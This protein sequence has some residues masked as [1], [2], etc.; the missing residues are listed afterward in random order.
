MPSIKVDSCLDEWLFLEDLPFDEYFD[1]SLFRTRSEN[2]LDDIVLDPEFTTEVEVQRENLSIDQCIL[3]SPQLSLT[4]VRIPELSEIDST[5]F[6]S[7]FFPS[8]SKVHPSSPFIPSL[9]HQPIITYQTPITPSSS[10]PLVSSSS[11]QSP[12]LNPAQLR[13]MAN[14]YAPLVF[15]APLGAMPQDYQNKII[16]FDGIGPY[17]T[18]QHTEKMTDH[19]ELHEID[20]EDVQM[21]LFAQTL[22]GDVRT[23]FRSLPANNINT[24]EVFYRKFLNRWEKK[25]NPLQIL[26][27]YENIKRG[28]N[29]TV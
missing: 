17:T 19:F 25:K 21:R 12:L 29:E 18:Q 23:W 22:A 11:T 14:R 7:P 10:L 4:T 16:Q 2:A 5:S 24:L 1:L 3:N 6:S 28:P 20:I 8:I 9:P 27:E 13:A 26:S 15:F